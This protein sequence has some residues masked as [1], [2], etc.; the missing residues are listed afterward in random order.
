MP[1]LSTLAFAV[2]RG[3]QCFSVTPA[4]CTSVK[5]LMPDKFGRPRWELVTGHYAQEIASESTSAVP[6]SL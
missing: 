4:M 6:L 5:A 2:R 1:I 3:R